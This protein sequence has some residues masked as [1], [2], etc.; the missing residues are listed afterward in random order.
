MRIVPLENAGT[1]RTWT[2]WPGP[3][4]I[5]A[6]FRAQDLGRGSLIQEP[7]GACIGRLTSSSQRTLRLAEGVDMAS[8]SGI[9]EAEERAPYR[10]GISGQSWGRSLNASRWP[11]RVHMSMMLEAPEEVTLHKLAAG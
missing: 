1:A 11:C 4:P 5:R 2:R 3:R 9:M 10:S 8:T 7:A 6:P